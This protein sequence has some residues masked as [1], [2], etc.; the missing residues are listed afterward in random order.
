M[1]GIGN[2]PPSLSLKEVHV[3]IPGLQGFRV[4]ILPHTSGSKEVQPK[5]GT[6]GLDGLQ[7]LRGNN[8]TLTLPVYTNT[9]V[10]EVKTLL[11]ELVLVS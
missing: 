3:K 8:E 2:D 4:Q 10:I 6:E 1:P 7:L 5:Q 11:E 9:K